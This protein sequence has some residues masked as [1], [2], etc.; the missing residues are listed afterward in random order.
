[1]K[2]WGGVFEKKTDR[3]LEEFTHSFKFDRILFE[4]EIKLNI[5]W[6][7]CL[8]KC[9]ILNPYEERKIVNTLREIEKE[10]IEKLNPE[11][12][13]IHTAVEE[14]MFEKIG[15]LA[16][17]IHTGRSRND[18]I[19][20]EVRMFLKDRIKEIVKLL[21]ILQKNILILSK[22]YINLIIPAYTHLRAAQPVLLSHYLLAYFFMLQRDIERFFR[23]YEQTDFLP[24]GSAAVSGTFLKI[25]RKYLGRLLSFKDITDNSIDAVSDRDFIIDFLSSSSILMMHLSRLAEDFIIFSTEKFNYLEIPE[26]FCTGSS[27]MPQ[28]KNPDVLELVRGKTGRVYGN[29]I[30]L[31]TTMKGLPL[32]Y[33]R[34]MQ[35]DK[36]RLFDTVDTVK[37]TLKIMGKILK[38]IRFN[39][40]IIKNSLKEGYLNATDLAEYLVNKKVP[41]K[42]AHNIV[43]EVVKFCMKRKKTLQ[44]LTL[45]ELKS[46]S[47]LF[48]E[49]VF[50]K[51]SFEASISSRKVYGGT[52]KESVLKQMEKAERVLKNDFLY[53]KITK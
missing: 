16:G 14:R 2:L 30:S 13:D 40:E 5:A 44:E 21:K 6:A 43:G 1:M 33:N 42:D 27:I 51:I 26:E 17:K 35:E 23:V 37:E 4:Y 18:Q 38:K 50:Q 34:D 15:T 45:S 52:S 22:K 47:P 46:F 8:R 29:L 11:S 53:N 19:A 39:R 10:G 7:K 36:E 48:E 12:E 9:K 49:D 32:S 24:L 41:F 31:L 28:K 20:T 25:D 3:I